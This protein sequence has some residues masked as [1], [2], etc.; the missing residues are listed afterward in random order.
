MEQQEQ[1]TP[2]YATVFYS[3]RRELDISW[4]EYIYLD[5]VY[6]LSHDGWCYKS[7][8]SCADDLG[9]DRASV[10]R[11]RIRLIHKNLL[12][13]NKEGH[14][15]TSVMYAKRIQAINPAYAKRDK[16]YAKRDSAVGVTQPKNNNRITKNNNNIIFEKNSN[17]TPTLA[18]REAQLT[19]SAQRAGGLR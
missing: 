18:A 1:I 3:V 6:H 5:M 17:G 4:N 19:L 8:Q 2:L 12:I 10:Y 15:K 14:V 11:M 9:I 7:L 13:K 16:P